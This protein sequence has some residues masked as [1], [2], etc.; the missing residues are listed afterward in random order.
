MLLNIKNQLMYSI[1]FLILF[2]GILVIYYS[3]AHITLTK[4]YRNDRIKF[5]KPCPEY[6]YKYDDVTGNFI[7]TVPTAKKCYE[8]CQQYGCNDWP[9]HMP[10]S[11]KNEISRD[12]YR[13]RCLKEYKTCLYNPLS[14]KQYTFM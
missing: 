8:L 2:E 4:E 1:S 7:C 13:C 10:V 14:K 3:N 9:F 12:G 5:F 6:N 11:L